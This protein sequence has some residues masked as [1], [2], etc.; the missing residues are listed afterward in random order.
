ME[1]VRLILNT[2]LN[3]A[4]LMNNFILVQMDI[5]NA[6]DNKFWHCFKNNFRGLMPLV[7]TEV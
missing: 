2:A 1:D 4:K 5:F 7:S 3:I 6:M